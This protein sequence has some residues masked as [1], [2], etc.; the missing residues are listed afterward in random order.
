M[1]HWSV[2]DEAVAGEAGAGGRAATRSVRGVAESLE[3]LFLKEFTARRGVA[4]RA[5]LLR[6]LRLGKAVRAADDS[7]GTSVAYGDSAPEAPARRGRI[8]ALD[9]QPIHWSSLTRLSRDGTRM[10]R[11]SHWSRC[12]RRRQRRAK[13]PNRCNSSW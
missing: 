5:W 9:C 2:T 11:S 3:Q 13:R 1:L 12:R 10:A 6:H 4:R 7:A 8:P